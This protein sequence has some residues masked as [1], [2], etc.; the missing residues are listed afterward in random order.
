M[1]IYKR[2]KYTARMRELGLTAKYFTEKLGITQGRFERIIHGRV[3][4]KEMLNK[5]KKL[6]K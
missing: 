5:I 3:E 2:N 4:D 1:E 6:L